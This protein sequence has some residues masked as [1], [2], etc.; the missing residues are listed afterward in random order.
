GVEVH[1]APRGSVLVR[2]EHW[3][4]TSLF[5]AVVRIDRAS[6]D[7]LTPRTRLRLHA[8]ATEVGAQLTCGAVQRS[9]GDALARVVTDAPIVVRGGD[10]FALRL[11]APLR[12]I[13]GGVV[14][15]RFARR[16]RLPAW[17]D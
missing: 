2:D 3:A 8:G 5:E 9:S 12:T 17:G 10:R 16:R 4:P 11:P 1:E 6:G 14:V 15:D 7:S 13:G